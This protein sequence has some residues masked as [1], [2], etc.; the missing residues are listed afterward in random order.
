MP[1]LLLH[2]LNGCIKRRDEET[3]RAS[4]GIGK[5]ILYAKRLELNE[6][7]KERNNKV[8]RKAETE[9]SLTEKFMFTIPS[10]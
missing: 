10:S 4:V 1:Q 8:K 2:G 5:K 9:K 6:G 3:E 7:K